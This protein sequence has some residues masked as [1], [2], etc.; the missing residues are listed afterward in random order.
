[1]VLLHHGLGSVRAWKAQTLALAE[2]GY[3][4]IAYDRWGYGG[5]DARSQGSMPGFKEDLL[6]L[7]VLLDALGVERPSLVGHSDGGTIALYYAAQQP[8]N[9]AR[10][11]VIA[12]HVYVEQKMDKGIHGVQQAFESD[13]RFR[14]GLRRAHGD[15]AESVFRNWFDGWVKPENRSWDMRP[16]LGQIAC[17]TLVIQGMDDEHASPQHALDIAGSIPHASLWLLEGAG[18]MLPQDRPEDLN[19]RLLEFLGGGE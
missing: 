9:V 16:V 14:E 3:R 18:H 11:V 12:A 7:G 13:A 17:P 10:L 4:V 8:E 2:A 1:V 6:D 19:F 5:S 15:K